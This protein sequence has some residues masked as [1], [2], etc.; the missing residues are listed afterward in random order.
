MET[1]LDLEIFDAINPKTY[2]IVVGLETP[3]SF[4]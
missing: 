4:G 2:P 1:T 3:T